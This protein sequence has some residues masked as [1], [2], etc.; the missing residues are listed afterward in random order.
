MS[1]QHEK[2]GWCGTAAVGRAVVAVLVMALWLLPREA[3]GQSVRLRV[4]DQAGEVQ[5]Q[6]VGVHLGES[7]VA[8]A[9]LPV[10]LGDVCD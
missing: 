6:C 5:A 2:T 4:V 9:M 10:S 3:V 7:V 8:A 1:G